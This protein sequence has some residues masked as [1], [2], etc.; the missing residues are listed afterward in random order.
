MIKPT[1]SRKDRKIAGKKNGKFPPVCPIS[2]VDGVQYTLKTSKGKA[3]A[4]EILVG[5]LKRII[6]LSDSGPIYLARA[7]DF[8]LFSNTPVTQVFIDNWFKEM[9]QD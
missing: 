8:I 5:T 2:L 4:A 9:N 6:A 1:L 7:G 3:N